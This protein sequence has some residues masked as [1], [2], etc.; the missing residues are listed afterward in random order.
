MNY[1]AKLHETLLMGDL[2]RR[3]RSCVLL[4]EQ[5][6]EF[7]VVVLAIKN[8]WFHQVNQEIFQI[9]HTSHMD[10]LI[11]L[12]LELLL[13]NQWMLLDQ[14][15]QHLQVCFLTSFRLLLWKYTC[16]L[17]KNLDGSFW[18]IIEILRHEQRDFEEAVGAHALWMHYAQLKGCV[19][20]LLVEDS[21]SILKSAHLFFRFDQ[22]QQIFQSF[23]ISW[24][25]CIV[26]AVLARVLILSQA[27]L[28][29]KG[30][31]SQLLNF[32]EKADGRI[33]ALVHPILKDKLFFIDFNIMT[34]KGILYHVHLGI[35]ISIVHQILSSWNDI[36]FIYGSLGAEQGFSY[37]VEDL[38]GLCSR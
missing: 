33:P 24:L 2:K 8:S 12:W 17:E 21:E 30:S 35:F 34:G 18:T 6:V 37:L 38:L 26:Q 13:H 20:K 36:V 1:D 11:L 28:D 16:L 9:P 14:F 3:L 27:L 4:I 19:L 22:F 32:L 5:F 25:C 31:A 23:M 7:L 29:E 15:M 10:H